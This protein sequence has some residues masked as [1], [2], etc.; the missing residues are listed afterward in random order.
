M[1]TQQQMNLLAS[2]WTYWIETRAEHRRVNIEIDGIDWIT[3]NCLR[4]WRKDSQEEFLGQPSEGQKLISGKM[5][6]KLNDLLSHLS[7]TYI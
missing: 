1:L 7:L 2:F 5:I 4:W 3:G 6:D